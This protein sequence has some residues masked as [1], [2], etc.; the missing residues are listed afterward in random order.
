MKK[1]GTNIVAFGECMVELRRHEGPLMAQ[2]FGGD[3]L[4]TATY[5]ARLSDGQ[6]SVQYATAI[7]DRDSFS[8]SMIESWENEGIKTDF[9][10]RLAG[11]LPGLYTIDVDSKGERSFAY[12]R[13]SSAA[14]QYFN[15]DKTPLEL[16]VDLYDVFYFSGISLAILP[17]A[18]RGRL[19]ALLEILKKRGTTV[20]FDNNY[21]ARL[22]TSP[23][24]CTAA[25]DQAYRLAD[26]ALVTLSDEMERNHE[27]DENKSLHQVFS[28]PPRELIIKRG[29]D[30]TLIRDGEGTQVSIPVTPVKMIVDTTAA[31]DSFGAGYLAARMRGLDCE[32]AAKVGNRLAAKVIQFPGAIIPLDKMPTLFA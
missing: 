22:W 18:A 19:Y 10:R 31:G 21:R 2:S 4:N 8:Q 27:T 12:W 25:Y 14:K 26:I 17:P 32:Q 1:L 24:E 5:L 7:G 29:A 11:Q 3:T 23:S 28:L 30:S 15:T 13:D 9:V 16:N 20:V 6:F